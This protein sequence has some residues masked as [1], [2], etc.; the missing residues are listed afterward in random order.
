MKMSNLKHWL[1][2]GVVATALTMPQSLWACAVCFGDPN[3]AQ[4]KGVNSAVLGMI[5]VTTVVL[6]G[7]IAL[8]IAINLRARRHRAMLAAGGSEGIQQP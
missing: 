8:I 4:T 6:S 7:F 5:G 2:A 1:V 3:S